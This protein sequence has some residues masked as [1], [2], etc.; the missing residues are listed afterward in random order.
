[1]K[2]EITSGNFAAFVRLTQPDTNQLFKNEK[3]GNLK[4]FSKDKQK[5]I[6]K[7]CFDKTA[8][9]LTGSTIRPGWKR[10]KVK[11]LRPSFYSSIAHTAGISQDKVIQNVEKFVK[12]NPETVLNMARE[13]AKKTGLNLSNINTEELINAIKSPSLNFVSY[14]TNEPKIKTK[15]LANFILAQIASEL[16]QI[17]ITIRDVS[18]FYDNMMGGNITEE[19]K[20]EAKVGENKPTLNLI[21]G[22]ACL[23]EGFLMDHKST[24]YHIDPQEI[25][26]QK[27]NQT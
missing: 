15:H 9:A 6:I 1:M 7:D 12:E 5:A 14:L 24:F 10:S 27:P 21:Q 16:F 26:P 8:E 3:K 19:W 20:L 17:N 18:L 2:V 25:L 23:N 11:E 4:D 13:V 22:F